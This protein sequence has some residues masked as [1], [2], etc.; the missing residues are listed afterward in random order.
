MHFPSHRNT[1][2]LELHPGAYF[3]AY[4]RL[5][6]QVRTLKPTLLVFVLSRFYFK[7]FY[8]IIFI[9]CPVHTGTQQGLYVR[10][11]Y[12]SAYGRILGQHTVVHSQQFLPF[13]ACSISM[14]WNCEIDS[15]TRWAPTEA[16]CLRQSSLLPPS[17]LPRRV[18]VQPVHG[19][20]FS[21][22]IS[23]NSADTGIYQTVKP[24]RAL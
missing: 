1:C 5:S 10:F 18:Y 8:T 3:V 19:P 11:A 13:F 20:L 21:L 17:A 7:L 9:L 6:Q 4:V 2:A 15:R 12:H 24:K 14:S 23:S 22:R 16:L